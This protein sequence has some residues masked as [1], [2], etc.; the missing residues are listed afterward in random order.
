MQKNKKRSDGRI[1]SKVY[2][3]QVDG[4]A[5]YKYVYAQN[6][7][8][9][10][11]KVQ[12]VKTKLGK[13]LDLSA[14]RDSFEYWAQKWLK[15]KK[16]EVS[17][18]RYIS[19][20]ARLNNLTRLFKYKISELRTN[21]FQDIM[22]DLASEP[23]ARTGKP[24]SKATLNDVKNTMRQ[25]MQLAISNR[26]IDYN[27]VNA[28][29]IPK[30]AAPTEEK[31]ALT[32]TEQRWIREY[33]HRAQAA[34]MIMMYAGL[35][36]GELLAL[37]WADIDIAAKTINIDKSVEF[38]KGSPH[39]KPGGKS[40][41]ATRIIYIPQIL[42]DYLKNVPGTHFGLVVQKSRGGLMT[43]TAWRRLWDSYLCDLNLEY[44]D[45]KNCVQ[46][47]G[48]RPSKYGPKEK[49]MLIPRITAHWLRHT[50][51]TLMYMA[52][53]DIL[54]AKEQAGHKD[55]ETTMGIYTHLDSQFKKKNVSKLDDYLREKETYWGHRGGQS[56]GESAV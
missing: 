34:A 32:E 33:P 29:T 53:V 39:V 44:G 48:K 11:K 8:E 47:K 56:P 40:D 19:Y 46:T 36:R 13:G 2:I 3:G 55:I 54:T 9:L 52:G 30:N 7:R 25:I 10:E 45:W 51:I 16:N 26:V 28:I 31:R 38:V 35:R 23:C 18:G 4:K 27:P 14:E 50:F 24:Y 41:A 15:L 43:D 17:A 6:N 1:R 20:S 21:D 37:T 22:L 49:P 42:A 5:Q 12:D